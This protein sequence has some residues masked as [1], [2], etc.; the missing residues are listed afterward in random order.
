MDIAVIEPGTGVV[1]NVIVCPS[2]EHAQSYFPGMKCVERK[3]GELLEPDA[4][5]AFDGKITRA[6]KVSPALVKQARETFEATQ[7]DLM[8]TYNEEKM[9]PTVVSV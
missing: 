4:V 9:F 5:Q 8:E 7:A 1:I 2:V 6:D 3:P